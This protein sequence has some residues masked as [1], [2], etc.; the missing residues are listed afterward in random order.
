MSHAERIEAAGHAAARRPD[1]S[2]DTRDWV[3][4]LS[5]AGPV[6]ERAIADLHALLLRVARREVNRRRTTMDIEGPEF[7]DLAHQAV[8][9]ALVAIIAKIPRFRGESRFTTWAYKFVVFEVSNKLGRH[10]W[11]RHTW[12]LEREDWDRLPDRFG[13]RPEDHAEWRDLVSA[14]RR[15]VEEE[16][17]DHQRAVFSA[18]ILG[19]VPADAL[20]VELGT[21]R[22]ALYKSVFDARR[23]LRA[24][25]VANGYL[26]AT[27]RDDHE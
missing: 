26:R 4:E 11:R 7:D 6:R 22:N 13:L 15:A 23:K 18:V 19:G 9:D 8:T 5:G 16:L 24:R 12:P 27:N 21:T 25:L 10:F 17:T 14:L 3:D 1:A 2:G 20:A